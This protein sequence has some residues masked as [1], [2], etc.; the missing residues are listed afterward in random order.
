MLYAFSGSQLPAKI[1][2]IA[3]SRRFVF[4]LRKASFRCFRAWNVIDVGVAA[5]P[6]DDG[7]NNVFDD[8]GVAFDFRPALGSVSREG[9]LDDVI[10]D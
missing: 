1:T 10:V 6:G 7:S 2:A 4:R 9:A 3:T 5:P 8:D